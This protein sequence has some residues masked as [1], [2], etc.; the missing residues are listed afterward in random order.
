M[1]PGG[2]IFVGGGLCSVPQIRGSLFNVKNN[3]YN[4]FCTFYAA[5][6]AMD[7]SKNSDLK[8]T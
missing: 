7:K 3:F 6:G 1:K 8:A 4:N 2:F 5:L